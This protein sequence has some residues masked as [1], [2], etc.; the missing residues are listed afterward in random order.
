MPKHFNDQGHAHFLT[1]S[2]Y[3]RLWLFKDDNLYEMFVDRL[4]T[5]RDKWNFKLY[6]FVIM[7]NHVHLVVLPKG[8]TSIST[9]LYSIKKNFS[10]RAMNYI[11]LEWKQIARQL[12]LSKGKRTLRRFWQEGGGYDRN[13]YS[14]DKLRDGIEYIHY[15]PV[16]KGFVEK[17]EDRKWSSAGYYKTGKSDV[18]TIDDPVW[19]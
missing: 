18:M 19:C 3:K 11:D 10:F 4:K 17:P 6:A 8:E 16:R 2:C 9:I 15:N 7:P 12:I 1:F 13:I 14:A 5:S